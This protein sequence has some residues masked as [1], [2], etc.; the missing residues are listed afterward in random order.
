MATLLAIIIT[1][2]GMIS[3]FLVLLLYLTDHS[4]EKFHH[5]YP[6]IYRIETQFNLPN[7]EKVKSAQVPLPLITA[8]QNEKTSKMSPTLYACLS[9]YRL[10]VKH[11]L[12]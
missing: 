8:L 9:T 1:A 12:T 7:G 6:Q 2:I 3:L 5:D 11:R 4:I 10:T